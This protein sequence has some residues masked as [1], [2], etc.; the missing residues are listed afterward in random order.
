VDGIARVAEVARAEGV[1][2]ALEPIHAA[3]A[4]DWSLVSD[5]PA[6]LA[7]LDEIGDPS[8]GLLVDT[9]HLWD[10]PDVEAHIR[11]AGP[12]I[13]A[14]HVNDHGRD[15]RSWA[16]RR[17]MGSG[18]IDVV[19]WLRACEDAGFRG[20]YDC[21]IFSDDG[22]LGV[23]DY[24]DSLWRLPGPELARQCVEAFDRVAAE[25]EVA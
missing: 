1:R 13:A 7:L 14:V 18:V 20:H 11:A 12:R 25:A 6:A 2:L 21:E 10:T 4:S 17:I 16:D 3:D 22:T 5:I 19:G 24:P 23:A 8:I 15:H 9:F